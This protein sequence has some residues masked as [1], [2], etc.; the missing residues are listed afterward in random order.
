MWITRR[1]VFER[2][3]D[4]VDLFLAAMAW[5][6]GPRGYG[7]WRTANIVNPDGRDGEAA[8]AAAVAAYRDAWQRKNGAEELARAW[9]RGRGKITG[10]GPAFASKVA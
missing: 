5:G 10:L 8:V 6:F 9:T 1:A 2:R 3:D 4:P 7:W